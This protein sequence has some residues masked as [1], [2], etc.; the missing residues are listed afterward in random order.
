MQKIGDLSGGTSTSFDCQLRI[1]I[2]ERK[3]PLTNA[4]AVG[5]CAVKEAAVVTS[6]SAAKIATSRRQMQRRGDLKPKH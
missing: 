3:S 4:L 5:P 1:L 2:Y 6:K